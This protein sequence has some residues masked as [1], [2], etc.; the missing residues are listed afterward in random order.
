MAETQGRVHRLDPHEVY[1]GMIDTA[2]L[3]P[4]PFGRLRPGIER[5]RLDHQFDPVLPIA[6]EEVHAVYHPVGG[7]RVLACGIG[8][9]K[10]AVLHAEGWDTVVPG[11]IPPE[12]SDRVDPVDLNMLVA[13]FTPAKVARHRSRRRNLV[14]ASLAVAGLIL[15]AGNLRRAGHAQDSMKSLRSQQASLYQEAIGEPDGPMPP[16]VRMTTELRRL[17]AT[18]GAKAT[19]D[20]PAAELDLQELLACWPRSEEIRVERLF[21]QP[22][23]IDI[24]AEASDASAVA[25]LVEALGAMN[26]WQLDSERFDT[27]DR[28][29]DETVRARLGYIRSSPGEQS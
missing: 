15:T 13:E 4:I 26:G 27:S 16:A 20:R 12:V 17:S 29:G 3:P 9:G 7:D 6:V 22:G 21:I 18:R 28:S 23:R 5:R 11:I 1:W 10:I 24:T 8:R 14:A 2:G 25:A 19:F